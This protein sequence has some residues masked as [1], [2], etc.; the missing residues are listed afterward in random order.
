MLVNR[1]PRVA[2][3][4]PFEHPEREHGHHK[5]HATVSN[6]KAPSFNGYRYAAACN[7]HR[8]GHH[9]R[10]RRVYDSALNYFRRLHPTLN[11]KRFIVTAFLSLLYFL[12]AKMLHG[13][14]RPETTLKSSSPLSHIATS[15]DYSRGIPRMEPLPRQFVVPKRWFISK[16]RRH[17]GGLEI[18]F[19]PPGTV[20][21]LQERKISHDFNE[22][23]GYDELYAEADDD[24]NIEY[25]YAF[26]DDEKRN[27]L[28]IWDDPDI[29]LRKKCRRTSWHRDLPIN[30]N[31]MHEFD[32]L[33][34][35]RGGDTKHLG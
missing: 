2:S 4:A 14:F 15:N 8:L 16:G 35:V 12:R 21:H 13:S 17:F 7:R 24:G 3:I 34:R 33:D 1:G 19:P 11:D 27:P 18:T 31:G 26:D 22:D 9:P 28:T 30:C 6:A 29:H 10:R 5:N 23:K 25:Y 32:F 20:T